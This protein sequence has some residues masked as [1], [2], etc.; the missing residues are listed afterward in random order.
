M[1]CYFCWPS[2]G[3]ANVRDTW[4]RVAL[5]A[6]ALRYWGKE[7]DK[8]ASK[9]AFDT[10]AASGLTFIDTAEVYGFGLSEQFTG[11]FGAPRAISSVALCRKRHSPPLLAAGPVSSVSA[12]L[13]TRLRASAARPH[14]LS[15]TLVAVAFG[16]W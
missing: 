11:E 4:R 14:A 16:T 9:E 7:Y 2:C 12:Y 15:T 13:M 1:C 8:E 10:L 6:C 5:T 3:D